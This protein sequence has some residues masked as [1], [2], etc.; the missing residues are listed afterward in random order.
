MHI[1]KATEKDIPFLITTILEA[2]KSGTD[3][4]SYS[5][6]FSI[7]EERFRTLLA[8]MLEEDIEGQELCVSGFRIAEN[9]EGVFMGAVCAWVE[10]LDGM[11]SKILKANVL[12][13]FMDK[14]SLESAIEKTAIIETLNF[15]RESGALQIESVYTDNNFRGK[16]VSGKLILKHIEEAAQKN[17]GL[18]KVQILVAKTN[19]SA[20]KAY[21]KL[22][23]KVVQEKSCNDPK[24]IEW[25]PSNTRV[26]M[27][28]FVNDIINNA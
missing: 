15:E 24:I 9:E 6:I 8:Q 21:E 18:N 11:P 1:R 23:F 10:G 28:C 27:E 20:L 13:H 19:A 7:S 25:L 5:N 4:L 14:V 3:K 2:E 17:P 16:G 12:L 26:M 22:G